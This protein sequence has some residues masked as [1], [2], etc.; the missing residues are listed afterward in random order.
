MQP[1]ESGYIS[2]ELLIFLANLKLREVYEQKVG[3]N[4]IEDNPLILGQA[5]RVKA[6]VQ[7]TLPY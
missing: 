2:G 5:A 4:E 1:H 6:G 7:R 3:R